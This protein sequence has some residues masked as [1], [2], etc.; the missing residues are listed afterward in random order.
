M[1][2]VLWMAVLMLVGMSAWAQGWTGPS[3]NDYQSS[4]PVYVQVNVNGAEQLEAEVAA[5]IDD[6]CRAVSSVAETQIG[7]SQYHLLRVWGNPD[8][9]LDKEITFKV[10]WEGLVFGFKKT[11]TWTGE[12]HTEIPVVLNV[13]KPTGIYITNPLK[14]NQK[15]NTTYDLTPEISFSYVD[16]NSGEAFPTYGESTI[17][18]EL[19]YTWNSTSPVECFT[20]DENNIL[21]VLRETGEVGSPLELT[22]SGGQFSI[23]GSTTVVITV[24][25]VPVTGIS[26]SPEIFEMPITQ[27]LYEQKNFMVKIEPA[28][29]SNQNY[30]FE[31]ADDNAISA[32]EPKSGMFVNAGL[33]RM[34]VVSESNSD[35]YTTFQVEVVQPVTSLN[36]SS[37]T[38]Y[39][40]VGDNIKNLV[41][42]SVH[43]EPEEAS[44]KDFYIEYP[45]D[46]AFTNDVAYMSGEYPIKVVSSDNPDYNQEATLYVVAITAPKTLEMEVG[47]NFTDLLEGEVS[48]VPDAVAWDIAPAETDAAAFEGGVA[49]EAGEYTLVVSCRE[50]PD[51]K[52]EIKVTVAAPVVITYPA[53]LTISK[54]K[55]TELTLTITEGEENFNPELLDIWI[56][57]GSTEYLPAIEEVEGS[58]GLKW[59]IRGNAVG[60]YFAYITYNGKLMNNDEG[61][62][63][64]SL[65]LPAEI[66]FNPAGWDWIYSPSRISFDDPTWLDDGADNR[67][68]EIRSQTALLYND[69]SLGIFGSLDALTSEDGMYKIKADYTDADKAVIIDLSGDC[70]WERNPYKKIVKG[71]NW[72]GY[73]NEWDM[74][75]ADLNTVE[76]TASDGDQIIGKIGFAE[77]DAASGEWLGSDGF[78]F[79]TGKGYLYYSTSETENEKGFSFDFIPTAGSGEVTPPLGQSVALNTQKAAAESVWQYDA[80]QFADNMAIVA[81][82]PQ[83]DFPADYTVGAFV[84][85]ECRGM[86]SAVQGGKMMISVAGKAGEHV[87]FRLHNELTGE[88]IDLNETLTYAQRAGSLKKPVVLTSEGI[89]TSIAEKTASEAAVEGIFDL[90]GRRVENMN[91]GGIYIIKTLENGKIAARKVIK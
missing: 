66:P 49:L 54:L 86:G 78:Y 29:A 13:D 40:Q 28:D 5:F 81:E 88:F 4:T 22:V 23:L 55:D 16:E 74:T 21:T 2:K 68:I 82:I 90:S 52:A 53:S 9:D 76:N 91:A 84:G 11:V 61:Y 38:F 72:I 64:L 42:P 24:P 10:A 56:D 17:E 3:A 62:A 57:W 50:Y 87:T 14:I 35:V 44:N 47:E 20:I 30:Y 34:K 59:N 27:S 63:K 39:A 67:V 73:P 77:Y 37:T 8:D 31:G 36:L 33:Y 45:S 60:R 46:D 79:Q 83:L 75:V 26:C 71:Y 41:S 19:T 15:L 7:N 70:T 18:T 69:E 32:Y 89:A 58:D 12:T 6:D 85:D 43:I 25:E 51:I 1:R 80:G 48:V 65:A